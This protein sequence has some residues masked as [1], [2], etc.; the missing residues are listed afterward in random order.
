[1]QTGSGNGQPSHNMASVWLKGRK[2][3]SPGSP[4]SKSNQMQRSPI[5]QRA[6]A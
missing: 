1:M 3:G 2:P 6:G 5:C 4:D